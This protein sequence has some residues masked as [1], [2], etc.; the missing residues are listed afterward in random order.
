MHTGRARR[1]EFAK[2][3]WRAC[4]ANQRVLFTAAMDMLNYLLAS[5]VDPA[6]PSGT[7]ASWGE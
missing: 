3:A 4:Q 1:A 5:Q 6:G 2:S 7:R